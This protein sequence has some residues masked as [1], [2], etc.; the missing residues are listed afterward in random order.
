MLVV[1][2]AVLVGAFAFTPSAVVRVVAPRRAPE[3]LAD[4][5]PATIC[6]LLAAALRSGMSIPSALSAVEW[7]LGEEREPAGLDVTGRLLVYGASWEDAWAHVDQRFRPAADALQPA[8]EDGSAPVPLLERTAATLRATAT[9]RA[10]ER[11][12]ELGVQLALPLG[13]CF[14]PAFVVLGV[15]PIVVSLGAGLLG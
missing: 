11:A 5:D 9:R 10:R 15:V 14:L 13:L 7:A 8:W 1:L 6:D 4:V 2:L 12:G 3:P